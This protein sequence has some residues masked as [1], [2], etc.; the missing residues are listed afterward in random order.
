M[1]RRGEARRGQV[2]SRGPK[3]ALQRILLAGWNV[4]DIFEKGERRARSRG[5]AGRGGRGEGGRRIQ[6]WEG[7]IQGWEG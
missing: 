2:V 4:Y 5:E 1:E 3:R 7:W 6:G